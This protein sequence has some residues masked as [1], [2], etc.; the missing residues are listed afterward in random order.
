[1]TKL[2]T[3]AKELTTKLETVTNEHNAL[4]QT[5]V[6]TGMNGAEFGDFLNVVGDA[7]SD[8]GAARRA[9]TNTS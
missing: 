1:M 2:V 8:D 9:P 6:D 4:L 7:R 3:T 5:V